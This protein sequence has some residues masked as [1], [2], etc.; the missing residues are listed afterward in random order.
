VSRP[1]LE[2]CLRD[3]SVAELL[4]APAVGLPKPVRGTPFLPVDPDEAVRSG[5][6]ERPLPPVSLRTASSYRS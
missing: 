1:G 2:E 6:F 3:V 5:Q 4:D